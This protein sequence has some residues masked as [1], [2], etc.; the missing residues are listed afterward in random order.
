MSCLCTCLPS[1]RWPVVLPIMYTVTVMPFEI[2]FLDQDTTGI[3]LLATIALTAIF[4]MD[5]FI[6]FNLGFYDEAGFEISSRFGGRVP[7]LARSVLRCAFNP[8]VE[9][10][11]A[12][13]LL[14]KA[15]AIRYLKSW[16]LLD[17]VSML[18]LGVSVLQPSAW[19]RLRC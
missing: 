17:F 15:I 8:G 2:F 6:N 14:R 4:A 7:E 18:P 9:C 10:V 13:L 19:F 3:W 16:F 5:L 11:L 12:T 1:A